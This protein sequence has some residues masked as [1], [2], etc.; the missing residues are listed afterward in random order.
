MDGKSRESNIICKECGSVVP[1]DVTY[2]PECGERADGK[3]ECPS[4]GQI[5]EKR[6]FCSEC[7]ARLAKKNACSCGTMYIG[8][9][10]P[11]CGKAASAETD[12]E[13]KEITFDGLIVG[14]TSGEVESP[15]AAKEKATVKEQPVAEAAAIPTT[16][17]EEAVA[18]PNRGAKKILE[19]IC[20]I[21]LGCAALFSLIFTFCMG[22]EAVHD[23]SGDTT[24]KAFSIYYFF[25]G[26]YKE[27]SKYNYSS[28]REN[29][30][31]Y[32][33]LILINIIALVTFIGTASSGLK[34]LVAYV[35]KFNRKKSVPIIK[36]ALTTYIFF[37][38]GVTLFYALT[39]NREG[40]TSGSAASLSAIR[41]DGATI[42]GLVLASVSVATFV[43]CKIIT[44]FIEQKNG[45]TVAVLSAT[46]V[47]TVVAIVALV[48]SSVGAIN[49]K[50]N[51]DGAGKIQFGLVTLISRLYVYGKTYTS[52]VDNCEALGFFGIAAQIV[53]ICL[54]VA[55]LYKLLKA[56]V[57]GS[58][59]NGVN[60]SVTAMVFSV[61]YVV[62]A[63]FAAKHFVENMAQVTVE[64]SVAPAIVALALA[65]LLFI[66]S[67]I[68]RS[69][70]R[71]A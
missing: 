53:L 29:F 57:F 48:M 58:Y 63:N 69:W 20:V 60:L 65:V 50:A 13:E 52:V 44:R 36:P 66:G 9:Y 33:P 54:V 41:L 51:I 32:F 62:F 71:K 3:A 35:K 31:L 40:Y 18:E 56:L 10:C 22:I 23:Y 49:L 61:A 37:V 5:V 24:S 70:E 30:S 47:L 46:A 11:Q 19:Y 15:N 7:G 68:L 17:A 21:S 34:T 55:M 27:L 59:F 64:M 16:P 38:A 67:C 45:Q 12:K 42:A 25:S 28:L 39:A 26:A 43:V 14:D 6:S 8:K 2:C 1:S 4:C